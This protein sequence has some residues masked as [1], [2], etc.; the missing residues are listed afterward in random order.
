M[1]TLPNKA[2]KRVKKIVKNRTKDPPGKQK[3]TGAEPRR[4]LEPRSSNWKF[5]AARHPPSSCPR[6]GAL[7]RVGSIEPS[8]GGVCFLW[9]A[10]ELR[11][12]G[13]R[14]E[15]Y[16]RRGRSAREDV[17]RPV[18]RD[19]GLLRGPRLLSLGKQHLGGFLKCESGSESRTGR[20][21]G[22][23][24]GAGGGRYERKR[25]NNGQGCGRNEIPA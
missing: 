16:R 2:K 13:Q 11:G 8:P 10:L 18:K 20:G 21:E 3:Q 12:N 24:Q 17:G 25:G 1:K 15:A 7:A 22:G 4:E 5:P 14:R 19:Q 6:S 9:Q 23:R